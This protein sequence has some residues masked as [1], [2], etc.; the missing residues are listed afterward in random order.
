MKPF[1]VVLGGE[2]PSVDEGMVDCEEP[3]VLDLTE[4]RWHCQ[5]SETVLFD[6]SGFLHATS[7]LRIKRIAFAIA[8]APGLPDIVVRGG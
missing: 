2:M 4:R 5:N 3:I 6:H 7:K 8:M 1:V